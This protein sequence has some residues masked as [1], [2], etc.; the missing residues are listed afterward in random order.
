[1]NPYLLEKMLEERRGEMLEEAGRLQLL[2]AY[3]AQFPSRRSR[4]FTALGK[5]LVTAGERLIERNNCR[6]EIGNTDTTAQA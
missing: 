2:A 1:M 4:L 5:Y 6:M 3:K